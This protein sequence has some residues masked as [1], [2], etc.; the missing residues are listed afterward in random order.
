MLRLVEQLLIHP[1]SLCLGR[2]WLRQG[3]NLYSPSLLQAQNQFNSL[4]I[5]GS[6]IADMS[7][8]ACLKCPVLTTLSCDW[9]VD[10]LTACM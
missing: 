2:G 8:H 10:S 4:S 6:R 7:H 1:G 5:L 9:S 3:L